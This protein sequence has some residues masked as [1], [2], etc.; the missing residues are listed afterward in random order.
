[1][2]VRLAFLLVLALSLST[3]FANDHQRS[4]QKIGKLNGPPLSELL[5]RTVESRQDSPKRYVF[6]TPFMPYARNMR[7]NGSS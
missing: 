2:L 6:V 3:S 1:M 7:A 5:L 4:G